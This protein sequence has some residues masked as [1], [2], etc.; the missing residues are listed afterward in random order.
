MSHKLKV[1]FD[2]NIYISAILFG[3]NPRQIL[4]L[5]RKKEIKLFV[6]KSILLEIALK[7]RV[8]FDWEEY[9][10][11][12]VIKGISKFAKVVSP[13]KKIKLIKD[14]KDDNAILECALEGEVEMIITGDKKHILPLGK[15]KDIFILSANQFLDIFYQ[16]DN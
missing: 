8:K 12:E 9:E 6:S 14:D 16:K 5:A 3:G 13:K 7:L 1:V 2:T 4:E 10:I 11:Q 15:F